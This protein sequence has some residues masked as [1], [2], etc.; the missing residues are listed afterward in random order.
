M[1]KEEVSYFLDKEEVQKKETKFIRILII[2]AV[3]AFVFSLYLFLISSVTVRE[4]PDDKF[5]EQ[6]VIFYTLDL[7]SPISA[8]SSINP[9]T[10]IVILTAVIIITLTIVLI[11]IYFKIGTIINVNAKQRDIAVNTDAG[12]NDSDIYAVSSLESSNAAI[13]ERI[14]ERYERIKEISKNKQTEIQ[15]PEKIY[16]PNN[17]KV[18]ELL[19]EGNK[20]LDKEEYADARIIYHKIREW[21]NPHDDKSRELYFRI[22]GFYERIVN[23]EI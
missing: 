4:N 2:I 8:L 6:G 5:E 21:Y 19:D 9:I 1:E 16:S 23:R 20:F 18:L 22:I 3:A 12:I 17:N 14:H 15:V 10:W 11:L 7:I 13:P